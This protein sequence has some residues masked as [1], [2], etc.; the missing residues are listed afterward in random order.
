[1]GAIAAAKWSPGKANNN[2]M[3]LIVAA[4]SSNCLDQNH[5]TLFSPGTGESGWQLQADGKIAILKT[6]DGSLNR[7]A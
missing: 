7:A 3:N 2:A 1:M 5:G 4:C 6:Q